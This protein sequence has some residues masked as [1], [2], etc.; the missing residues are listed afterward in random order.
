MYGFNEVF[1]NGW[2]C[3]KWDFLLGGGFQVVVV[4]YVQYGSSFFKQNFQ[5]VFVVIQMQVQVIQVV[6]CKLCGVDC[7]DSVV[8]QFCLQGK[9]VIGVQSVVVDFFV[10]GFV[11]GFELVG[12][13]FDWV[14][15]GIIQEIEDV[16]VDVIEDFFGIVCGGQLLQLLVFCFLV[17]LGWLCQLILQVRCFEMLDGVDCVVF[18]Q[19]GCFLQCWYVVVG[20]V[21]YVDQVC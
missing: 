7:F 20:Q 14:V 15:C 11:E 17:F 10:G 6:G 16:N 3:I 8:C 5:F 1:I 4:V 13:C 21:Y 9:I 2:D 19:C 18:D 12:D